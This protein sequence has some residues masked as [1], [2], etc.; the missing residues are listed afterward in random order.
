MKKTY[1]HTHHQELDSIIKINPF[2]VPSEI[3]FFHQ[4]PQT[5]NSADSNLF[6]F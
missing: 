4:E 2:K 5:P 1:E 6:P 3:H